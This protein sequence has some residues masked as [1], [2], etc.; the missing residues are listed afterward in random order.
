[1]SFNFYIAEEEVNYTSN[2][3]PMFLQCIP[4][5]I[6]SINQATGRIALLK[7][8]FIRTCMEDNYPAM[9]QLEPTNGHGTYQGAL[10][11][12]NQLIVLSLK[13]RDDEWRIK[14]A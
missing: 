6:N 11:L 13:Y 1:M 12:L 8:R 14:H 9:L 10:D 5:G 2:V 4:D 7:L 3:G